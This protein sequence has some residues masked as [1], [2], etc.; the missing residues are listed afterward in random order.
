MKKLLTVLMLLAFIVT[1]PSVGLT[2]D[3]V[4]GWDGTL[5]SRGGSNP[6]TELP[7]HLEITRQNRRFFFGEMTL[8][9]PPP[10]P[11]DVKENGIAVMS[12][13]GV[14]A[15]D[16]VKIV[17][18]EN[19]SMVFEGKLVEVAGKVYCEGLFETLGVS[20]GGG[21]NITQIGAFWLNKT[22]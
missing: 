2:Q 12:I 10:V 18:R 14:F 1:V 5:W 8:S 15:G 9:T 4:G 11:E 17:E 6:V 7:L 20:D 16:A 3:L 21:A 22:K 13:Y 19:G